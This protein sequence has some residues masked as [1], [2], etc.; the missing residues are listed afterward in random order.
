MF[1]LGEMECMGACVN[2][3]MIAIADYTK[4]VE[5]F[6]YN[7]YE[8]RLGLAAHL[9]QRCWLPANAFVGRQLAVPLVVAL[10]SAPHLAAPPTSSLVSP[11]PHCLQDLTPEDTIKIIDTLKKGGKPKVRLPR[12]LRRAG[13]LRGSLARH[14]VCQVAQHVAPGALAVLKS[15]SAPPSS[16]PCC[17]ALQVGSQHRSKAEP[18]GAVINGKWVP[19]KPGADGLT[20]QGEQCRARGAMALRVC[21]AR[22]QALL[23]QWRAVQFSLCTMQA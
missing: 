11:L 6:S 10:Q 7:Y 14:G 16:A 9:D 21:H 3:P 8:A 15:C 18:A 12:R 13:L 2:A 4:G 22:A 23:L 19:S 17:R 5:G 1:T 20:L